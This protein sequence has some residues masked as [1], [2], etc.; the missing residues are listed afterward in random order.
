MVAFDGKRLQRAIAVFSEWEEHGRTEDAADVLAKHEDLRDLLEPMFDDGVADAAHEESSSDAAVH[1]RPRELG[2]YRLI[3]ELGRGGMGVVYEAEQIELARRVVVKVLPP[4]LS[5]EAQLRARFRREA[6]AAAKLR[7]PGIVRVFDVGEDDGRAFLAMEFVD[8]APLDAVLARCREAATLDGATFA[9]AVLTEQLRPMNAMGGDDSR[10][11]LDSPT[12]NAS[13]HEIMITIAARVADAL[14]HAHRS[15]VVHRDVKPSNI[16]IRPDGMPVLVDFG[17]ARDEMLP[18]V[19]VVGQFA[20]TPHYVSPEQAAAGQVPIDRRTDVFSLGT[21]LFEMLT[22]QLPFEGATKHEILERILAHEARDL[23]S[24]DRAASADLRAVVGKALERS[25]DRRYESAA[26][27]AADLRALL[28]GRSVTARPITRTQR[29]WRWAKREPWLAGTAT[30]GLLAVLIGAAVS[31]GF[32]SVAS[33]RLSDIERLADSKRLQELLRQAEALWP[34]VPSRANEMRDWLDVGSEIVGRLP[35][36]RATLAELRHRARALT[37]AETEALRRASPEGTELAFLVERR[38][39]LRGDVESKVN[40]ERRAELESILSTRSFWRME[41][42]EAQWQHDLLAKLVDDIEQFAAPQGAMRSMRTR[43][44]DANTITARSTV[45]FAGA[46]NA[47]IDEIADVDRSPKYAGMRL[48]PMLGLAPLGKDPNSGLEEFA[49]VRTGNVPTR[50][51]QGNL[52]LR[53]DTALVMVLLPAARVRVGATQDER[54]GRETGRFDARARGNELPVHEVDLAAFLLGKYEVTRG[55]W[56][57]VFGDRAPAISGDHPQN[58]PV[59]HVSWTLASSFSTR[60]GCDLPTESQWEYGVRAGT[61]TPWWTGTE[62]ESLNGRAN[63][64]DRTAGEVNPAWVQHADFDDGFAHWAPVGSFAG[65]AFGLHD[66]T[67]NV[68]EWCL[69]RATMDYS[70]P[71]RVD[72]GERLSLAMARRSLRGGA[73]TSDVDKLRSAFRSGD[74]PANQAPDTGVR[75]SRRV[76]LAPR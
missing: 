21:T 36:H 43:L 13:W 5:H 29:A 71:V 70:D 48:Q 16:L 75:V 30:A 33:S 12:W 69:D 10:A 58:L 7:H 8:G 56:I 66:M 64:A 25:I 74:F 32:A 23:R 44:E 37:P 1:E 68:W 73:F 4:Q 65:N 51:A 11:V 67:G 47:V 34:A 42:E 39:R 61:D 53:E 55:Q 41:S 17:L 24:A 46:W 62:P 50:D 28:A 45:R 27:F 54:R 2:A 52:I 15:G 49:D 31:L 63:L 6:W 35:L 18:S 57:A 3:R 40:Q 20:G 76:R 9:R 26:Q 72:T 59:A 19:T 38:G 60:L 14:D 22:L